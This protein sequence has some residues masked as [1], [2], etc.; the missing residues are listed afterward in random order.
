MKQKLLKIGGPTAALVIFGS[1]WLVRIQAQDDK[2]R[3]GMQQMRTN[4]IGYVVFG[5]E[6]SLDPISG[7]AYPAADPQMQIGLRSDGIVVW[8]RTPK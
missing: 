5:K 2:N 3:S 4:W 8:R 7:R 6:E 1:V